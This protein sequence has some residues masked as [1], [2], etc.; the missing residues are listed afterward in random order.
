MSKISWALR[1]LKRQARVKIK[2]AARKAARQGPLQPDK[3]M[4][5]MDRTEWE[6]FKKEFQSMRTKMVAI[7]TKD[8]RGY[9]RKIL[10]SGERLSFKKHME[11]FTEAQ[12][13]ELRYH[14]RSLRVTKKYHERYKYDPAVKEGRRKTSEKWR[15][16]PANLEALK[17]H[18]QKHNALH[19][20]RYSKDPVYRKK[21]LDKAKKL[22]K[23]KYHTDAEYREKKKAISRE[24]SRKAAKKK[25]A[26]KLGEQES[27]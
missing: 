1:A 16:D 2:M 23:E 24:R 25:K 7:N 14:H 11:G 26:E 15:K 12:K 19:V 4:G 22:Q 6:L 18:R 10:D 20:E 9:A 21:A 3:H 27:E 8:L 5:K 13:K 17:K